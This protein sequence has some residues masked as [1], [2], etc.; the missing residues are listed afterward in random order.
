MI[1]KQFF[2][3]LLGGGVVFLIFLSVA[4]NLGALN[5]YLDAVSHFKLQYCLLGLG[6]LF[7]FALSR[8]MHWSA[9]SLVL[10]L[11]NLTVLLPWYFP[12]SSSLSATTV[13]VRLLFANVYVSNTNYDRLKSLI[14][15]E[16]P[17]LIALAEATPAWQAA[18]SDLKE[19]YPYSVEAVEPGRDGMLMYS[20]LPLTPL[21]DVGGSWRQVL[22]ATVERDGVFFT[23][24][25]IHP[26][27]PT[28]STQFAAR[29]Q[30]LSTVSAYLRKAMLENQNPTIVLGDFNISLWSPIYQQFVRESGLQNARR[31]FGILPTWPIPWLPLLIPIDHCLISPD[32]QVRAFQTGSEIGSDHLPI[33]ADVSLPQP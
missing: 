9:L 11:I 20:S 18:L 4:G 25:A 13:P 23:A 15:T 31:G 24:I 33:I 19:I 12:R 7:F 5:V 21:K 17:D 3:R 8:Q 10:I 28:N 29:N 2:L 14:R 30:L 6:A 32:I 16:R 22:G 1:Q 26:L 27:P